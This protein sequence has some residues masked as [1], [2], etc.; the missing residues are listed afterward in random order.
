MNQQFPF[1]SV[2]AGMIIVSLLKV[3]EWIINRRR[4]NY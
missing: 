1:V 2:I 3:I 4:K